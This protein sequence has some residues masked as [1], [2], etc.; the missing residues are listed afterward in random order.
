MSWEPGEA[1]FGGKTGLE[2]ISEIIVGSPNVLV[3]EGLLA[4]ECGLG[5]AEQVVTEIEET[6]MFNSI[7]IHRDLNGRQRVITAKRN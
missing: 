4:L 3:N 5:Q 6:S 2:I 1:L 7:M